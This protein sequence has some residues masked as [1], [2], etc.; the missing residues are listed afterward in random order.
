M[1][2]GCRSYLCSPPVQ[3]HQ[4][5]CNNFF[6]SVEGQPESTVYK[7]HCAADPSQTAS[8]DLLKTAVFGVNVWLRLVSSE[9]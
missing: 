7:L 3:G 1:R 6:I 4:I 2:E 9:W 5:S 8:G